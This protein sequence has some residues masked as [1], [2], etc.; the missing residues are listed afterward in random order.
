[1]LTIGDQEGMLLPELARVLGVAQQTLRSHCER[2]SLNINAVSVD[3]RRQLKKEGIIHLNSAR[4]NFLPR[5]TIQELVRLVGTPEA[6]AVYNQLWD[7]R[8]SRAYWRHSN[9]SH[10]RRS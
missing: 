9:R 5:E 8:R 7:S 1:M 6:K 4:V 3:A 2:H 10:Y